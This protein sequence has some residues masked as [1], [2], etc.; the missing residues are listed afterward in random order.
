M[1]ADIDRDTFSPEEESRFV[2][3]LQH[4]LTALESLLG[5]P[6]F[7]E[8]QTRVGLELELSLVGDDG[9]P[10][11][12]NQEVIAATDVE[13]VE[14]ELDRFNLEYN[15][16]PVPLAGA[17][18]TSLLDDVT[19][20]L[21]GL[22]ATAARFDGRIAAVGILPTLRE[23]D[24]QRDALTDVPRFRA[25]SSRIRALRNAP[26]E[27]RVDGPEPIRITC[28]DVTLEGANTS[29][30][31]HLQVHPQR[32]ARVFN[33]AQIATAPVLALAG[34]SP[35]VAGRQGWEET[36]VAVFRQAVDDRGPSARW[37]PA[38]VSF[39]NGWLKSG[40]HELFAEA[41]ALH[42]PLLPVCS[43]EQPLDVLAEGGTP[44][45]DEL[46]LHNGTVW[47][48]NRPVYDP[49]DGGHLRIEFRS[50][51]SGP[52][53]TDMLANVA[54]L[55]GL[56]AA[57]ARESWWMTVALPFRYAE[58]NFNEAARVGLDATLLWPSKRAPSPRPVQ[59][60]TLLNDLIPL[61]DE[62]LESVGVLPEERARHL[63]V[64]RARLESGQTGSRWQ[65]STLIAL[66][67]DGMPRERALVEMVD[68][69]LEHSASERPVHEWP[70]PTT[71]RSS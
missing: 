39:G 30:Q 4:C 16:R 44:G 63:D 69:Y 55:L 3:R 65:R 25:I 28:D 10:L 67:R 68:R 15:A 26:F 27:V 53:A 41:V 38:R 66:E 31:I 71:G 37:S 47:R 2:M 8:G 7:G 62:G 46:R 34:N 6:G 32:F 70:A 11:L 18:F 22:R 20:A 36:R 1:G 14:V 9:R 43:E 12:R 64:L 13:R 35:V 51:P 19:D 40:G 17:P 42:T 21:T 60:R 61:A 59:V 33:A 5:R 48:W 24:L 56:T 23:S 45:L 57:L 58:Y 50:L 29:L 49:S 54:L 52:T